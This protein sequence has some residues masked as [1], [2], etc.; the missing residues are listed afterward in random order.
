M[1][2][3]VGI[4]SVNADKAAL[5]AVL[6]NDSVDLV[7]RIMICLRVEQLESKMKIAS[8]L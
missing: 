4:D 3:Q 7:R 5:S 2:C 6:L 1:Y 8:R